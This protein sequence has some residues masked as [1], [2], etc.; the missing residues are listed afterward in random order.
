M[1]LLKAR[2]DIVIEHLVDQ[3]EDIQTLTLSARM[4]EDLK[5][6]FNLSNTSV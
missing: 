1:L 6:A 4:V 3:V 2:K 5:R